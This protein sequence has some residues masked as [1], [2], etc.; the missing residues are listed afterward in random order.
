M[1]PYTGTSHVFSKR[2]RAAYTDVKNP[3]LRQAI[4][5]VSA[6]NATKSLL[7]VKGGRSIPFYEFQA[8]RLY[9]DLSPISPDGEGQKFKL[10]RVSLR[11]H[12][13]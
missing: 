7:R 11:H 9:A 1:L 12:D 13:G 10:P 4:Q 8:Q 5:I 2:G 3:C 6:A